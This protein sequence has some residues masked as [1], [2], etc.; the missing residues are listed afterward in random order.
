M[1]KTYVC[2][3]FKR[4]GVDELNVRRTV[5]FAV[6]KINLR[7]L[8]GYNIDFML[9]RGTDLAEIL[10]EIKAGWDMVPCEDP[11][12]KDSYIYGCSGFSYKP[13]YPFPGY[14]EQVWAYVNLKGYIPKPD[15]D[16]FRLLDLWDEVVK[17][18]VSFKDIQYE[19]GLKRDDIS[20][21]EMFYYIDNTHLYGDNI[22]LKF[23]T[24]NGSFS[25]NL[26]LVHEDMRAASLSEYNHCREFRTE[27]LYRL[28]DYQQ[29][30]FVNKSTPQSLLRILKEK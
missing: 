12:M 16:E 25:E 2:N 14:V 18:R 29:P 19:I 20:I 7:S 23:K 6:M 9:K 27:E 15:S 30:I 3:T 28:K 4:E 1:E 8:L 5:S 21:D 13:T 24:E 11:I 22:Y 10:R 26:E 17:K